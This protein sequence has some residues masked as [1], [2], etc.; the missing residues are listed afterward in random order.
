M[1][2]SI[3]GSPTNGFRALTSTEIDKSVR[4]VGS[5]KLEAYVIADL[6]SFIATLEP[7]LDGR[8]SNADPRALFG[9]AR[10]DTVESLADTPLE[11]QRR[12]RLADQTF[13][14][15]RRILALGASL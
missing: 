11:Q 10:H 15:V 5:Q 2:P 14:L 3:S 6:E 1:L 12:S 13:N 7:A 9:C 4:R 8:T